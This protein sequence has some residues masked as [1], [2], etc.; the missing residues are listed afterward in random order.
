M[1]PSTHSQQIHSL[2]LCRPL[3]PAWLTALYLA[4]VSIFAGVAFAAQSAASEDKEV[5]LISLLRSNAPP[6]DKA[7]ACK[8]LAIYGS[9]KAV[10]LGLEVVAGQVQVDAVFGDFGL[11]D[12]LEDQAGLI[13]RGRID[14]DAGVGGTG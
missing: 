10:L 1:K 14:D 5:A 11:G 6:Q 2:S 13:G 12:E 4:S 9:D 8:Q 3:S 7:I